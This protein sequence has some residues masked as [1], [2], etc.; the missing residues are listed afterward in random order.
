MSKRKEDALR[1]EAAKLIRESKMP[2]LETLCGVLVEVRSE[3]A[4]RI[5][6]ARREA[7]RKVAVN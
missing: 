5:R 6:R 1:R 4:N 7:E 2:S 3:Y